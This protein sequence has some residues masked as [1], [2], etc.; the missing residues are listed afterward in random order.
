[1]KLGFLRCELAKD[2]VCK[3]DEQISWTGRNWKLSALSKWK[4]TLGIYTDKTML[5][6]IFM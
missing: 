6:Y 2:G 1:M 3:N 5:E 4:Q